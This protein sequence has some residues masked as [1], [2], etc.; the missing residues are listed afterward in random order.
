MLGNQTVDG[1]YTIEVNDG[2]LTNILQHHL[3]MIF[4]WNIPLN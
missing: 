3:L 2:L 4:G 1:K